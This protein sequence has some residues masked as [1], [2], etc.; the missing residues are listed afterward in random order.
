MVNELSLFQSGVII[1][2]IALIMTILTVYFQYVKGPDI[3]FFITN[4]EQR[5]ENK[6]FRFV[7]RKITENTTGVGLPFDAI[8]VNEG[9][10]SGTLLPFFNEPFL[11][12]IKPNGVVS[13]ESKYFPPA[14][15][16]SF[17]YKVASNFPTQL[18]V[19][20]N[21]PMTFEFH[22][23][24]GADNIIKVINEYDFFKVNIQYKVTTRTGIKIKDKE[25]K[26]IM[27]GGELA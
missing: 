13:N 25:I 1:S 21:L 23:D 2:G 8:F 26:I 16:V 17:P 24:G 22:I 19:G 11:T 15:A 27:E 3:K 6:N 5:N 14:L 18:N 7:F 10:R 20:E 4:E 9:G 12:E